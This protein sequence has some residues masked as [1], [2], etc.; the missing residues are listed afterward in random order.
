MRGKFCSFSWKSCTIFQMLN[1]PNQPVGD[2]LTNSSEVK[3]CDFANA[4]ES[5]GAP[6][7][8][9]Y[10][11]HHLNNKTRD[12]G[13]ALLQH[14]Q[15]RL[16]IPFTGM[17][18]F[19]MFELTPHVSSCIISCKNITQLEEIQSRCLLMFI[20]HCIDLR[21]NRNWKALYFTVFF[22]PMVSCRFSHQPIH[23]LLGQGAWFSICCAPG[24]A[25]M[26]KETSSPA[27]PLEIGLESNETSRPASI[28]SDQ[29]NQNLSR[30]M[31][32]E[33]LESHN[34]P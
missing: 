10:Y 20:V 6:C 32:K 26:F 9:P 29:Q 17:A 15:N 13:G 31:E 28:F 2:Y 24:L 34:M 18:I 23:W 8:L 5:G 1:Q 12:V 27:S 14:F 11:T 22:K 7:I 21:D 30:G 33:R 25:E 4:G 3:K 16:I 19:T